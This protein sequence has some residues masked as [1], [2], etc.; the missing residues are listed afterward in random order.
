METLIEQLKA[1]GFACGYDGCASYW[2]KTPEHDTM[3]MPFGGRIAVCVC[4][5]GTGQI[6]RWFPDTVTIDEIE[7][8]ITRARR[9]IAEWDTCEIS[10][11]A[12]ILS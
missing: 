5:H 7:A 11:T 10:F 9:L 2:R 4:E 1:R 12:P 8:F 3:V 6:D